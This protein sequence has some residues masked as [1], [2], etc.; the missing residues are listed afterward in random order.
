MQRTKTSPL[1]GSTNF[2]EVLRRLGGVSPQRIRAFPPPGTATE[3][4]VTAIHDNENRLYELIDGVLVEKVMGFQESFLAIEIVMMIG[5]FVKAGDLGIVT[6]SDGTIRLAEG[7]VRIPDVAF[8]PWS[9]FPDRLCPR[10]PI[11]KLAPAL[12][13]EVLSGKNTRREM[14]LKLQDYFSV[15]V[16]LVWFVDPKK[17][18][19]TVY[20]AP[21]QATV[22]NET[23]VLDGGAV[24]AGFQMPLSQLFARIPT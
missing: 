8:F 4:D 10:E 17:R 11:P 21:D 9:L 13:V 3:E 24:L 16:L 23:D 20:T 6:G 18:I 19:V 5:V 12:A 1:N 15:G 14:K 22:L 2:A 7:L